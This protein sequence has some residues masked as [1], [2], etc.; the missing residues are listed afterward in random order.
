MQRQ[1]PAIGDH[2][3]ATLPIH[4][5]RW[6]KTTGWLGAAS[7]IQAKVVAINPDGTLD[8]ECPAQTFHVNTYTSTHEAAVIVRGVPHSDNA[9]K[10]TEGA[11]NLALG[12]GGRYQFGPSWS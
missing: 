3:S 5:T 10:Y 1:L 9:E 12:F 2:V 11:P 6:G 4:G 8:L 7:N